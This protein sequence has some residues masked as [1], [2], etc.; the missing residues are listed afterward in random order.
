MI[1]GDIKDT[2]NG[3][4]IMAEKNMAKKLAIK[5]FAMKSTTF[6]CHTCILIW[7]IL[8]QTY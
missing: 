1:H 5:C 7:P 8:V 2:Q 4:E 3:T 6:I